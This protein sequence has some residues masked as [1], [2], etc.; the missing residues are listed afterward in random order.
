MTT[1]RLHALEKTWLSY[2]I[3]KPAE[4]N[5]RTSYLQPVHGSALALTNLLH[6]TYAQ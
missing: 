4:V 2:H 1:D 6:K 5:L 3:D